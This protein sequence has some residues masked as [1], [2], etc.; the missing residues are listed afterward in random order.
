ML[1][2]IC[3]SRLKLR[4]KQFEKITGSIFNLKINGNEPHIATLTLNE[5]VYKHNRH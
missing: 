1:R 5:C 3:E 2:V 4:K